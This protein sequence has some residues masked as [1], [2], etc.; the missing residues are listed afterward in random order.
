MMTENPCV[1]CGACCAF[2][3]VS[4]YWA[5]CDDSE[6][7]TVPVDRTE[8]ISP[9]HRCMK[10]THKKPPYCSELKGEI[11]K[12]ALCQIY[13]KRPSTCREFGIQ[14]QDGYYVQSPE[15]LLRCNQA[16]LSWNLPPIGGRLPSVA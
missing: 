13:E 7:G 12:L 5:E 11:G 6:W 4:F 15:D 8:V 2:F 16:R 14:W 1:T 3:R 10:G 9:F